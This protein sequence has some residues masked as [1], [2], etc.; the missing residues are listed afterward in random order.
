MVEPT[1]TGVFGQQE[2]VMNLVLTPE[3][4]AVSVIGKNLRED[5][6]LLNLGVVIRI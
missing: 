2:W 6:I 3:G 4:D 1:V 5:R